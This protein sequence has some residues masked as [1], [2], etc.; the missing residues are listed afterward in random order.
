VIIIIG[1]IGGTLVHGIVGLFIGPITLSVAR[2]L[3]SAWIRI[4]RAARAGDLESGIAALLD[5]ENPRRADDRGGRAAVTPAGCPT[6]TL[7]SNFPVNCGPLDT[8]A[9]SEIA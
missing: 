1:V 5:P 2:E 9:R 6:P 8:V 4:D 3:T 7:P